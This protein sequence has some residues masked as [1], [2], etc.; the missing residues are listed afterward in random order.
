[1]IA[2]VVD[3]HQTTSGYI[4]PFQAQ[5]DLSALASLIEIAF[6]D[7]LAAT[8]SRM[9]EDMRQFALMGPM[10]WMAQ[11]VQPM[12]AGYV[13]IEDGKLVGNITLTPE[14][15]HG[16][17]TISNVAVLPAYRGRG[18]AGKLLDTGLNHLRQRQGKLVLLQVRADNAVALTLYRHRGFH[19]FDTLHEM[20]LPKFHL[21]M[22]SSTVASGIRRVRPGDSRKLH[23]LVVESTPA[24]VRRYRPVQPHTYRRG[25][26]WSVSRSLQLAFSGQEL[27][28]IVGERNGELAAYASLTIYLTRSPDEVKLYVRPT[29]RGRWERP[30]LEALIGPTTMALHHNLRACISTSH[31]EGLNAF[32]ELHFETLRI[33]DQM[34]LELDPPS[35]QVSYH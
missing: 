18:I 12:L 10:L 7:E 21:P 24:T 33:L 1:M 2:E 34:A 5:R 9:V 16:I 8:G 17:W 26:W 20:N 35:G 31:P 11:M 3:N 30:L 22:L 14:K 4:R 27:V 19:T 25:L 28:E 32:K 29:E 23:Q 6:K 15:E 13:W